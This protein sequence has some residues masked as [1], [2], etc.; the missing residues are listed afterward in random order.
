MNVSPASG[1]RAAG[2]RELLRGGAAALLTAC[3]IASVAP[4]FAADQ[5]TVSQAPA[6]E[7]NAARESSRPRAPEPAAAASPPPAGT[8]TPKIRVY[9]APPE[10]GPSAALRTAY[11]ALHAGDFGTATRLYEEL[12]RTEPRNADVLLGLASLALHRGDTESARA[13]YL[14]VLRID[15]RHALAQ[16]GLLVMLGRA[17]YYSAEARLK[18]LAAR[19]PAAF[20]YHTLGNLYAEQSLWPQA[21][22]AYFQAYR[23]APDNCD[24][25]YNLAV[26]LEHVGQRNLALGYY[27][28]AV[29]L[30]RVRGPANFDLSRAADRIG[31]LAELNAT[32]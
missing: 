24:Y 20:I 14:G 15:P 16:A 28:R 7:K 1:I 18:E 25:A 10:P 4:L 21:Q 27:R 31:R 8:P 3:G 13:Y 5:S 22:R 6:A 29:E 26:G 17:D 9:R 32:P 30:A 19:E 2:V 11:A 12:S 23:L